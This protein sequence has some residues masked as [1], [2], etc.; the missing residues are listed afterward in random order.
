MADRALWTAQELIA[1]T[2]GRIEGEV[3]LPLNGVT[4]DS[5]NSAEGD[6]FVAIKGERHDGH[7][8]VVNAL[9]A[10]AGLAVVSRPT[11]DMRAAGPLLVVAEDPLRGLE[12][13][14][15]AARARSQAQIIGVTGSVGKTS[16]KEMLR[17]ALSASGLTHARPPPSTITGVCR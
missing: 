11:D 1:A 8:F 17:V 4:I 13:I 15:R 5:R 12:N 14:G 10:G 16:T 6:I 9:Q 7:D 3:R 2:G